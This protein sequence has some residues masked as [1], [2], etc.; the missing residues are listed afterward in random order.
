MICTNDFD[1]P[2]KKSK[3]NKTTA[4]TEALI[5]AQATAANLT[6]WA[7]RAV[8]RAIAAHA[9]TTGQSV[10]KYSTNSPTAATARSGNSFTDE[11]LVA[12]SRSSSP[13]VVDDD[14]DDSDDNEYISKTKNNIVDEE[15]ED[16]NNR[17]IHPRKESDNTM[18]DTYEENI[19][20]DKNKK[21]ETSPSSSSPGFNFL[22]NPMDMMDYQMLKEQDDLL[23]D[24]ERKQQRDMETV[25]DEMKADVIQ[26]LQLFGI[27]YVEA[28]AEAEA[29]CVTLENLGLVDGII[30]ED[31]DY[32]EVY[33]AKDAERELAL[34]RN[35]MVALAM[36]LG[37]DYT[38]GVKGVGIVNGMEILQTFSV[39][40]DVKLGLTKFRKWL[41]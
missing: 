1:S 6:N 20:V 41:D 34:S 18:A 36:L 19:G 17:D 9:E 5:Q 10:A 16:Q 12:S 21:K 24:E 15:K 23:A 37:G 38:E 35:H 14:D 2:T 27:P 39:S 28:P 25:T 11:M 3:H 4:A 40:A 7:G 29:Q 8:R 33:L 30:T 13:S 22:S 31:S 32:V 26:L